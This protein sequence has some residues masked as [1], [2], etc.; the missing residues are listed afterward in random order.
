MATRPGFI[1]S[2]TEWVG[3]GSTSPL[4]YQSI[5]PTTANT[6]DLWVRSTDNVSYVWTGSAWV[7]TTVDLS[8][9][10][11]A[12]LNIISEKTAAFTLSLTDVSS[13]IEVNGTFTVTVPNDSV[14]NFPIGSQVSLL[15]TG[16]GVITIAGAAGVTVTGNPGLKLSGQWSGATLVKRAVNTWALVGDLVA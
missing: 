16:T 2:G 8:N 4:W 1:W 3:I 12:I 6:G 5:A 9:Y 11:R 14:V 15:G 7:A 13:L 10:A